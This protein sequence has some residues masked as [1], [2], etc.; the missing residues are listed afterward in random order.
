MSNRLSIAVVLPPTLEGGELTHVS[1]MIPRLSQK[2][3]RVV[4]ITPA[5][6]RD[7]FDVDAATVYRPSRFP[8]RNYGF[9][10]AAMPGVLATLRRSDI[11][12]VH[13]HAYPHFLAD[14]L[15]IARPLY[16]KPVVITF[17]GSFHQATTSV[18]RCLKKIHN[19]CLLRFKRH[20][21]KFVAVSHAERDEVIRR[22]IPADKLE[23]SYNGV[24]TRYARLERARRSGSD[25]RRVLYLGRLTRSKNPELLARALA[26]VVEED[27]NVRLIYAG[28]DWGERSNLEKVVEKLRLTEY[29]R[30]A[31]EVSE[32]QKEDL[33]ASCD[34]FVHPSLQDIFSIA[35]LE[36]SLAGLP[37]IAFDIGG[38]SRMI[39]DGQTGIL[40]NPP[41]EEGLA[42]AILDII[43]D[44]G[45]AR[46]MGEAG[47]E[48]VQSNF[49]WDKMV[50]ELESVYQEVVAAGR[51]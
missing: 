19:V 1:E 25:N 28:A 38:M 47:R 22:G 31:G 8:T 16:G 44:E 26:R 32:Q 33:L 49:S 12:V 13:I 51:D 3:H 29:V 27:K 24:S 43:G 20:V 6:Y 4:L 30:F 2:G 46:K 42:S 37:V 39:V 45:L 36:A 21:D 41:N 11:D 5:K 50:D 40:V 35:I 48:Y 7:A 10:P 34:V 15:T 14:F 9:S 23:V 17:H 18:I